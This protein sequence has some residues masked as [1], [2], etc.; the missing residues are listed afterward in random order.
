MFKNNKK[1][2]GHGARIALGPASG[3]QGKGGGGGGGVDATP[4]RFFLNF[5][6]SETN[7]HLHLPF[8]VAVHIFLT[9]I[10]TQDW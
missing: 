8:S 1:Q 6:C 7:Y 2:A 4:I 9:H 10:L 3:V 5:S